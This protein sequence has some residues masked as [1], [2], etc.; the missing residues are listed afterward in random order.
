MKT[1]T[2][3]PKKES[4]TEEDIFTKLMEENQIT[5]LKKEKE[6]DHNYNYF[7][8][9]DNVFKPSTGNNHNNKY[10]GL[11]GAYSK[12]PHIRRIKI[13]RHFQADFSLDLHG[14]TR[15]S[16]LNKAKYAFRIAKQKQYQS[17]LIIT[18]KGINSRQSIGIIKAVIWDWL[19]YQKSEGNIANFQIAPNFL[20]GGGAILIFFY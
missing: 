2:P 5:P 3:P 6:P 12:P 8:I 17:L 7:E 19:S 15:E 13:N 14:E 4:D 11:E 9:K 16:A 18:G 20:G 1:K 10:S